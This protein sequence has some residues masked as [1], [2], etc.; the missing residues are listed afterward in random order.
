MP[1]YR[2]DYK[3]TAFYDCVAEIEAESKEEAQKI[4]EEDYSDYEDESEICDTEME[5]EFVSEIM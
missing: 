1:M 4:V 2:V 5:I 3:V